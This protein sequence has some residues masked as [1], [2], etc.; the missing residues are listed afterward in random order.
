MDPWCPW[1]PWKTPELKG[2]PGIAPEIPWFFNCPQKSQRNTRNFLQEALFVEYDC[3]FVHF[4]K[5]IVLWVFHV[6]IFRWNVMNFEKFGFRYFLS[7]YKLISK[8]PMTK[9]IS[10]WSN[11]FFNQ[12]IIFHIKRCRS[13]RS[14]NHIPLTHFWYLCSFYYMYTFMICSSQKLIRVF[15]PVPP[16][17]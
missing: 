12:W 13:Y 8:P 10:C 2:A 1:N 9:R 17:Y 7:K 3:Y 4:L 5:V 6:D 14:Y 15:P 11:Q 16:W